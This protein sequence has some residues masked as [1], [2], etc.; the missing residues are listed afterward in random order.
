MAVF[1]DLSGPESERIKKELTQ[2]FKNHN[3]TLEIKCNLK[4]VDYLDI[5][6]NLE[7][8]TYKPYKKPNN[9][10]RYVHAESN[11][12]PPILKQIPISIGQRISINSSSKE[13]FEATKPHY[14]KALDNCGYKDTKL[15][16]S[17][18]GKEHSQKR[19]RSRKIIWF[20]PPYSKNVKTNI[21]KTFLMLINKHVG[22]KQETS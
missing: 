19:K 22:K 18:T 14:E 4:Q 15:Q 1:K 11:H 17:S 6:F 5:T 20:N 3:L 10:I 2:I 7:N 21:G 8:G 16:F 13:I 9:E 12:P